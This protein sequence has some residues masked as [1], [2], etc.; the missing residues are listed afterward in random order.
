MV[1]CDRGRGAPRQYSP[2]A[3]A[4]IEQTDYGAKYPLISMIT[5][6]GLVGDP[7]PSDAV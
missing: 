5:F 1:A 2:S 4:E 6:V 7:R 3:A